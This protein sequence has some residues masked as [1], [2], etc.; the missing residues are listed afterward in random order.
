[1]MA[2][3]DASSREDCIAMRTA[4]NTPQQA[5]T[6]MNDPSF[7]EA[8]RVWAVAVLAAA[9]D[10]AGRID[11]AFRKALARSPNAKERDGLIV[12]LSRMREAYRQRPD[13][14]A[15][16]LNTGFAPRPDPAADKVELAAWTS[17]CRVILNLHET[18]TRY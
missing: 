4:S 9:S 6:L 16:L 18:V 2:N 13:D 12:F 14:A 5:L 15:K 17:V 7:V 10:D 1:M 11:A 8:A 3:F